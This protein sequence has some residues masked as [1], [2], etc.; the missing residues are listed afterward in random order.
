L[1]D[2]N[3]TLYKKDRKVIFENDVSR[4]SALIKRA[5]QLGQLIIDKGT[6]IS[7]SNGEYRWVIE[8]T[9]G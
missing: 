3:S 1:Q 4:F 6:E 2:Y 7:I 9:S 8:E 5:D